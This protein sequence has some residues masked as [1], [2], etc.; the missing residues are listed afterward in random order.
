LNFRK[1]NFLKPL[2]SA[3]SNILK[4][5]VTFKSDEKN[6]NGTLTPEALERRSNVTSQVFDALRLI[7]KSL[8]VESVCGESASE[9][10]ADKLSLFSKKGIHIDFSTF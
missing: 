6:K 7:S 5:F 9:V 3:V 8:K 1:L 4:G 2:V 10:T